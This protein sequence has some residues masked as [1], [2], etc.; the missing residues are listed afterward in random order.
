MFILS[1]LITLCF[2][3]ITILSS[4]VLGNTL[5]ED[6]RSLS[7]STPPRIP[8]NL[9]HVEKRF[10]NTSSTAVSSSSTAA[11]SS[12]SSSKIT[13]GVATTLTT[14]VTS[15]QTPN[16]DSEIPSWAQKHEEADSKHHGPKS[17]P[18][19]TGADRSVGR[20]WHIL[21][22]V[23]CKSDFLAKMA[24]SGTVTAI[25]CK[26]FQCIKSLMTFT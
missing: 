7:P 24:T 1:R 14:T 17:R 18:L 4:G 20:S 15:K 22:T 19:V 26:A 2:L 12:S 11:S 10:T 23:H 13:Q 8:Y 3:F 25:R 21:S 6:E 16:S 9:I 5:P